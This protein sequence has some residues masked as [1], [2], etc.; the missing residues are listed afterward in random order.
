MKK[1]WCIYFNRIWFLFEHF[2]KAFLNAKNIQVVFCCVIDLPVYGW[3]EDAL[4]EMTPVSLGTLSLS[5][6]STKYSWVFFISSS[7]LK[8]FSDHFLYKCP[9][10]FKLFTFSTSSRNIRLISTKLAKS[11]FEWLPLVYS[12]A[13]P[14]FSKGRLN[15]LKILSRTKQPMI[16][17]LLYMLPDGTGTCKLLDLIFFNL[18]FQDKVYL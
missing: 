17:K 11:I 2:N 7:E 18:L 12:N 8:V 5:P 13:A 16:I 6:F 14:G 4:H 10:V 9:S 3:R 15:V 1:A